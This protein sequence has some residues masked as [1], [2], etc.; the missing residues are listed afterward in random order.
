MQRCTGG[1]KLLQ[2]SLS[3]DKWKVVGQ[4]KIMEDTLNF[5]PQAGLSRLVTSA[6]L[7]HQGRQWEAGGIFYSIFYLLV[8]FTQAPPV[9]HGPFERARMPLT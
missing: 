5:T 7:S 8:V 9:R 6:R 3:I 4:I 2:K 1:A